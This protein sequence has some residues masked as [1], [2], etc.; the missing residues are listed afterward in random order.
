MDKIKVGLI[1]FGLA[2]R[3]FHEPLVKLNSLILI[4]IG[5]DQILERRDGAKK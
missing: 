2:S 3:V 4:L 1:G 5:L